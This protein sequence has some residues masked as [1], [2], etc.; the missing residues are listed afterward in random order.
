MV[1]Y[2]HADLLSAFRRV[3]IRRSHQPS[4]IK[5]WLLFDPVTH[6]VIEPKLMGKRQKGDTELRLLVDICSS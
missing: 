3:A 2:D 6:V 1:T 4:W 5:A